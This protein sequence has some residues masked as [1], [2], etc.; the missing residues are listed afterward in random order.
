MFFDMLY[1]YTIL[2]PQ[3]GDSDSE[4]SI[5]LLRLS[6]LYALSDETMT[7][8]IKS[9]CRTDVSTVL[10]YCIGSSGLLDAIKYLYDNAADQTLLDDYA[11]TI[12]GSLRPKWKG[13]QWKQI[14]YQYPD[15]GMRLLKA[16]KNS[17]YNVLHHILDSKEFNEATEEPGFTELIIE[18]YLEEGYVLISDLWKNSLF[19][20]VAH[21]TSL[22]T[23]LLEFQLEEEESDYSG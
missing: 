17:D 12:V 4:K 9:C 19:R 21:S 23:R 18:S 8:S 15:F 20:S 1:G 13:T 3:P 10:P 5:G 2:I 11:A 22:S 6:K 16:I 14:C 7:W